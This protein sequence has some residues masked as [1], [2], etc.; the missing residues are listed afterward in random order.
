M[1][2]NQTS[3]KDD[4]ATLRGPPSGDELERAYGLA[5]H[6][7]S[8]PRYRRTAFGRSQFLCL[9]IA[10]IAPLIGCYALGWSASI[11]VI[12]LVIDAWAVHLGDLLV[13]GLAEQGQRR[14]RH[15]LGL[16][17]Y[18]LRIARRAVK[19]VNTGAVVR[20]GSEVKLF[21]DLPGGAS[22]LVSA[23]ILLFI[24]APVV[25]VA[26]I[27]LR[28]HPDQFK[29]GWIILLCLLSIMV[30]LIAA[31]RIGMAGRRDA[32][33]YQDLLPQGYAPSL[34]LFAAGCAWA[35]VVINGEYRLSNADQ[36]FYASLAFFV[37][38]LVALVAIGLALLRDNRDEERLLQRFLAVPQSLYQQLSNEHVKSP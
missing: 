10:G 14:A 18:V 3:I 16:R 4:L 28:D 21:I 30:R 1:Q 8:D 23:I 17:N 25:V 13:I 15:R 24:T 11:V 36:V 22:I 37:T 38:Y 32:I 20:Y 6:L 5:P 35:V 29:P 34:A 27:T 19:L 26:A 7:L 33:S 31:S 2:D 12:A 9:G